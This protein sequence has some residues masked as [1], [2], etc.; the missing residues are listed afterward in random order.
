[1]TY[2][3][4]KQK[5]LVDQLIVA[6][7]PRIA[8][9]MVLYIVAGLSLEYDPLV[10]SVTTSLKLISLDDL[11]EL[12]VA[13]KHRIAQLDHS[14]LKFP[15]TKFTSCSSSISFNI[16]NSSKPCSNYQIRESFNK[17]STCNHGRCH[18]NSS[19]MSSLE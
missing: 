1:M 16:S 5:S 3:L 13:H 14:K 11:H 10:V 2:Y 12:F 7:Q 6:A 19:S 18:G 8:S 4:Q 9:N 17:S 15:E